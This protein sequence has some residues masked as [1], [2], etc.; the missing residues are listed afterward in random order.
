MSLKSLSPAEAHALINK[1]AQLID[2]RG[3]DE[4]SREHIP[5]AQ[6]VPLEKLSAGSLSHHPADVLIFQCKSGNRTKMNANALRASSTCEAFILDGGIDA[7]KAAGLAVAKDA[8]QPLE[9]NRQVQIT[10]G[11][12]A[13]AGFVLGLTVYPGFYALSGAIG[14]G[15]VFSG[16]TGTCAMFSILKRMPWNRA[17]FA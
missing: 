16:V 7:W 17:A 13:F 2:I 9:L 14:A 8:K 10:A 12:F 1:G 6:S 15:L 5:G 4:Y 3:A 11:G